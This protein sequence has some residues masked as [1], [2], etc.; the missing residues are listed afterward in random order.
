M[1]QTSPLPQPAVSQYPQTQSYLGDLWQA[2]TRD[3]AQPKQEE[4]SG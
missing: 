3:R 4:A 2:K 1:S